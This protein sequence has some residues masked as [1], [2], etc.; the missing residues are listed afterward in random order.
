MRVLVTGG[1]GFLGSHLTQM[2]LDQGDS[3][4]VI[5]DLSTGY[6]E[7]LPSHSALEFRQQT[8]SD[9]IDWQGE[10]IYHLACPASPEKYQK[11]HLSTLDTNYL[12]TRN[13]LELARATGA[14]FLFTSTS[15][16]YGDPQQSPQV[17]TYWGNVNSFGPRSCYDEG[18]RVGESLCYAYQLQRG[19]DCRIARIFNTYGPRMCPRDGRV[20]TNFIVQ[21]LEGKAL[22]VYGQGQQ[23]RSLCY[24]E[25]LIRG[26]YQLMECPNRS[27]RP[28]NLGNPVEM[29]V[30]EIAQLA[31][32]LCQSSADLVYLPL[33]QDDPQRRRPDIRV[34]KSL[35]GWEPTISPRDGMRMTVE[36]FRNRL[37]ATS[38]T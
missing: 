11:D 14:R 32:E 17:E 2:L 13:V 25:D 12:G 35:L 27:E 30:L 10:R 6:K 38:K 22:T 37:Q 21:A 15:E 36:H 9:P 28:V 20:V 5:D 18:K 34:A 8:V 16:V 4:L 24:V 7:N 19:V 29:T 26:L 33:P 31:R 1:A 23:T 3:V